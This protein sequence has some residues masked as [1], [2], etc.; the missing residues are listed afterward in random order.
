MIEFRRV[1]SE[2][3]VRSTYLN[4][5]DEQGR[6]WGA[7]FPEHRKRLAIIDGEGRV[8]FA[9]KHHTNQIWGAIRNWFD[10][11]SVRPGTVVVVRHDAG[12]TRE[13]CPVVYLIPEGSTAAVQAALGEAVRPEAAEVDSEIPLSLE[14]QLEDFLARN[15]NLVEEGLRLYVDED[16]REGRQYP[17]D[18]GT[19]DLLCERPTGDFLVIELKRGK[20][21]DV[22]VG[23]T[24][25]YMGWVRQHIAGGRPVFGLVL[26]HDRDELLKYA[27]LAN[28]KLMLRYFKLRLE[29][30]SEE[31][32]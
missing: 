14:R 29:L 8:T 4:L 24:S 6:T 9:G 18:V 2:S 20:G 19:I 12:E 1:V 5:T 31:E 28:D 26:A 25:R 27:I 30:V 16:G 15:L 3:E 10:D 32:L 11:N 23:Q 22:V 17:T 7:H 21:S 13:G